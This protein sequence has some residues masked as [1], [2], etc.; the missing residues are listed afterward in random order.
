MSEPKPRS[1]LSVSDISAR[2]LSGML[3][4]MKSLK[5]AI[6][7]RE[8]LTDLRGRMVGLLFEKPSTRTRT[9]FEVATARLGGFPVYLASDELQSSRGEP[10][11]DTARILGGYLDVIVG[12]VY[13]HSTLVEMAEHSGV[14]VLNGLSDLEH[15]TQVIS[16][17]FTIAETKGKLRG[18]TLAFIGDGGNVCNSLLLGA[19]LVGMNMVAA[20]PPGYTP[21]E[22]VLRRA[23]ENARRSGC[24]VR[25]VDDPKEAAVDSDVVYTDVW[26]S[27]GEEKET[28]KRLRAF[29]GFQVN[30]ETL[31]LAS[32]DAVV[33]HCLPAH[34]GLEITDDVIEGKQSVVWTQG[35]NKLYGAAVALGFVTS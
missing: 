4:R 24:T 5:P 12:R 3:E 19:S 33:M 23:E 30:S 2:E 13:S 31:K 35:E 14:P 1:L 11:K 15:P 25:V 20:C 8:P 16:D 10:V 21:D 28:K 6:R 27:M 18:L 29:R 7:R 22:E 34:R 9:S 17:L 32:K 26:V